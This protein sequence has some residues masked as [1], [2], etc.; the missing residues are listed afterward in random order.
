MNKK[1]LSIFTGVLAT[2]SSLAIAQEASDNVRLN[3]IGFYPSGPK[4]AIVVDAKSDKFF[5]LPV[6]KPDTV[7][8]GT[9]KKMGVWEFSGE[10]A[11]KADFSKFTK[12]GT[13]TLYVPGV[14]SSYPFDIKTK[15]HFEPAKAS[16]RFYYYQRASIPLEE[17]YAGKVFARKQVIRTTKCLCMLPLLLPADLKEQ[18]FPVPADGTMPVITTNTSSI[19]VSVPI[20]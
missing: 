18:C 17:K 16:L 13:Y 14:G 19:Q 5:I 20:P 7:F 1:W 8:S 11:S 2:F 4:T 12:E 6:G 9:L 3:Q 10:E 15:V